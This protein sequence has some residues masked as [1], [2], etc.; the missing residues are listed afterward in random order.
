MWAP[1]IGET[2]DG[3]AGA[4]LMAMRG[5]RELPARCPPN[6]AIEALHE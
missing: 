5:E 6:H 2:T 4:F 1:L 3:Q